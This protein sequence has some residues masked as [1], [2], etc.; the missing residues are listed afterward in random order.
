M[1]TPISNITDS[2]TDGGVTYTSIKMVI[3]DTA[4][5]AGSKMIDLTTT[6]AGGYFNVD[7]DGNM[8]ISGY[9]D[10]APMAAPTWAEGRM[11]YDSDKKALS[12]YNEEADVTINMGQENVVRCLNDSGGDIADGKVVYI[13]GASGSLPEISK[14]IANGERVLGI[15]TH[16]IV[17]GTIGYVTNL[18]TV[19]G[20]DLSSFLVGDTLYLSPSVAGEMQ[21]TQPLYPDSSIEMGTVIDNSATG[22][23]LVDLEHHGSAVQ[24]I[25]SY[26]FTAR[27]TAVGEYFQAGFYDYPA[28]DANLTQASLTQAHGSANNSYAAHAFV[29]FGAGSTDGSDL[30]VT[31]S[32][33][34]ITDAGVRT[35]ADSEAIVLTD[36]A[37]D[38][39]YETGKKWLGAILYTLSSTG[40]ATYSLDFNYGLAK[41]DDLNNTDFTLQGFEAVGLCNATDSNFNVEL[42]A[43]TATG[44]TYSA[45]AFQA[46]N[47]PLANMN[48][49]HGT[50]DDLVG[51]EQFAFKVANLNVPIDGTA[52]EGAIIRVTTGVNNSVSFMNSHITVTTN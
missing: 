35:P 52:S 25:K 6:V 49:I 34:S 50:E 22:T 41:Y 36:A 2:W 14:A 4:Y 1:T 29:V 43:H 13:S 21:N 18:G 38:E 48:T 10:F 40:G 8:A 51:G 42:L 46:G 26:S 15:A 32:G 23:L 7:V 3:T 20:F 37:L 9:Q 47:T 28:A 44:W 19:S 30:V 45:A 17:D 16:N 31:V 24:V 12:Y 11:Y 27:T 5:A 33:T 39:Y